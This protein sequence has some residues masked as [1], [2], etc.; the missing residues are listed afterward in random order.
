MSPG[1]KR[2]WFLLNAAAWSL[3]YALDTPIAHGITGKHYG[4]ELTWPQ[5]TAHTAALWLVALLVGT[6]QRRALAPYVKVTWLRV[7]TAPVALS[8]VFW[9][10]WYQ[11]WID[12]FLPRFLLGSLVL[13][14]WAWI[15]NLPAR[16]HR[17]AATFAILSFPFASFVGI[18]LF[19]AVLVGV[20]RATVNLE[21]S[22]LQHAGFFTAY[23][24]VTGVLGGWLSGLAL[25][26]FLPAID[27][28][29]RP[30]SEA[31]LPVTPP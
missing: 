14:S 23:G 18:N 29:T 15:G 24:V 21:T 12:P 13:G 16:G 5:L 6:A 28:G 11:P 30:L 26:R 7:A 1:F 2:H 17:I 19:F 8:I 3:G 10:F 22:D 31:A 4:L 9:A 20:L 27:P 25:A